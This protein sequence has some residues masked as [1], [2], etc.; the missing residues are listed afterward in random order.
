MKGKLRPYRTILKV[1]LVLVAIDWCV[2]G[3]FFDAYVMPGLVNR[4]PMLRERTA[5]AYPSI[6]FDALDKLP[7][8][9]VRVAF[10]GDSTML[11]YGSPDTS[12]IAY[13]TQRQLRRDLDRSDVEA[14]DVSTL[15][16]YVTDG[17]IVVDKLVG[18]KV[19]VVV[20]GILL[21]AF[22]RDAYAT[23][24]TRLREE[25]GVGDM[26]RMT[27]VG[28]FPWLISNVGAE[29]LAGGVVHNA[30][31]TY[32]YRAMLSRWLV[33]VEPPLAWVLR[34]PPLVREMPMGPPPPHAGS[35]ELT[36]AEF[37]YPSPSWEAFE[38]LARLCGAYAPS[39]CVV[40]GGPVNPEYR[41]TMA[42]PGLYD[43]FRERMRVVAERN[44]VVWLDY[45]DAMTPRDFLP[46][47]FGG[48][49]RDAIHLNVRGRRKLAR[50]LAAPIA[51]IVGKAAAGR[52]S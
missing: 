27:A 39:R 5:G 50:E 8:P 22:A 52:G 46:A 51:A 1:L 32:G 10:V 26:V 29:A 19:D 12:T 31:A 28:G 18:A 47:R 48:P 30:W 21:R 4:Y 3:P 2:R 42:E 7:A 49:K 43:E 9:A 15:G 25:I 40:F 24:V 14:M 16:L 37:G 35:F 44:D 13:M 34:T 33:K 17:A 23:W 41:A 6:V 45:T 11:A 38:L 36:R 20:Y